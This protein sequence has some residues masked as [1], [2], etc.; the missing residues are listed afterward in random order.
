[1]WANK[2]SGWPDEFLVD[3]TRELIWNWTFRWCWPKIRLSVSKQRFR[4]FNRMNFSV[5]REKLK[6]HKNLKLN[7]VN[8]AQCLARIR[9][10]NISINFFLTNR[11][12]YL[13][14]F[15][16][17]IFLYCPW[18][19]A[20]CT[21]SFQF[22]MPA[23]QEVTVNPSLEETPLFIIPNVSASVAKIAR[24]TPEWIRKAGHSASV[25]FFEVRITAGDGYLWAGIA[26]GCIWESNSIW[27]VTFTETYF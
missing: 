27:T 20:T 13:S 23:S 6:Y 3:A 5:Q 10:K 22:Y 24:G 16:L 17:V 9:A 2:F 19:V 18:F 12:L 7:V 25:P 8:V 4:W 11:G 14:F 21:I 26:S 15:S 1:M